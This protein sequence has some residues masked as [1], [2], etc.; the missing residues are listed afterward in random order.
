M[1]FC[2]VDGALYC[3]VAFKLDI[4]PFV[5][6]CFSSLERY[7]HEDVAH[8]Y[9]Q[10]TF[11]CPSL[12]VL[13]FRGFHS[14]VR[15]ILNIHLCM[16]LDSDPCFLLFCSHQVRLWS[17]DPEHQLWDPWYIR[18]WQHHPSA[19]DI[20]GVSRPHW[21]W[22]LWDERGC[23]P[24]QL[25]HW[26]TWHCLRT[27]W[28]NW[29]QEPFLGCLGSKLPG[30]GWREHTICRPCRQH[31]SEHARVFRWGLEWAQSA[32]PGAVLSADTVSAFGAVC[33][34]EDLDVITEVICKQRQ[35]AV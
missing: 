12:R 35:V 24:Q 28:E 27:E 18:V 19:L 31:A 8:V 32:V 33:C 16:G 4:V 1:P 14:G 2:S 9:G 29:T 10:D 23:P 6:F 17:S 34:G 25:H 30:C 15:P 11:P 5:H 21:Q 13:W 7:V 20:Q 3:R 26:G 22:R